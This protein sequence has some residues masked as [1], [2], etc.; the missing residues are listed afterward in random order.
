MGRIPVTLTLF[1]NNK[2]QGNSEDQFFYLKRETE[3]TQ[4]IIKFR[5]VHVSLHE[6]QLFM[7]FCSSC[8]TEYLLGLKM[9]CEDKVHLK[10]G[11]FS[12]L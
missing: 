8:Q 2:F 5:T 12:S 4:G 11:A 1:Q 10:L 9:Q 7:L 3:K 6:G